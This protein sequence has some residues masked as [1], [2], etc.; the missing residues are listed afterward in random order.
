MRTRQAL[1]LTLLLL[2]SGAN[3]A[4]DPAW[5]L[6]ARELSVDVCRID[7]KTDPFFP[8]TL[9]SDWH[10]GAAVNWDVTFLGRGYWNNRTYFDTA[11]VH[12]DPANPGYG[13]DKVGH[14]GWQS[15]LGAHVG[16]KVDIFWQHHS[17]HAADDGRPGQEYP[18]DD[19]YGVRFYFLLKGEDRGR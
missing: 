9:S 3:A 12:P 2:A 15:E 13:Y 1:L 4:S 17:Q 11:T 16:P 6:D 7:R 10:W 18:L 5:W 19:R 14:V 8:D